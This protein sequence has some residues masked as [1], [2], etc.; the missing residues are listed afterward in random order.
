MAKRSVSKQTKHDSKVKQIAQQLQKQRYNV[1]ADLPGYQ[2][3]A[4]IGK[5]KRRPD[6]EAT[7]GAKR[8]IIEVETPET[9]EHDKK[10]HTTFRKSAAHKRNTN[11][12]IEVAE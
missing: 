11:F 5:G 4:P 8:K 10:Q 1:K 9:L 6:I 7:K 2:R 3:P 12:R